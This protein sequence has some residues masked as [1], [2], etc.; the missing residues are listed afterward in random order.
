MPF[1]YFLL[2]YILTC[3]YPYNYVLKSTCLLI[4]LFYAIFVL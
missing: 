2:L 3:L 4:F 1:Y